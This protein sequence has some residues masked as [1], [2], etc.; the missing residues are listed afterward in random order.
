MYIVHKVKVKMNA[1]A[2]LTLC[3]IYKDQGPMDEYGKI[4]RCVYTKFLTG[5]NS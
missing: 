5:P 2:T 4:C 1:V 3:T